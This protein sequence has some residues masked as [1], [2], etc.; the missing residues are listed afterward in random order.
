MIAD[1]DVILLGTCTRTHGRRG[2]LHII[3]DNDL[4]SVAEDAEFLLFR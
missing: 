3:S 2:E 4:L 1:S